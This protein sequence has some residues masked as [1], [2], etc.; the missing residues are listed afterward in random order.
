MK[1][2]Q[3]QLLVASPHLEDPNFAR[4]VI[5]LIQHGEDGTF[6]LVL[7]RPIDKTIQEL[8]QEV[9]EAPCVSRQHINLGGPVSGPLMALHTE[10]PLG[11]IEILPGVY[12]SAQKEHLE[13]LVQRPNVQLKLFIGHSGW[14]E[15]QLESEMDQGAWLV[16]PATAA[17]I[18]L[19]EEEL[20]PQ[21]SR[22]IGA[23]VLATS[24]KIKHVPDDPSVN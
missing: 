19:A 14:S 15:G 6:G 16:A 10:Q 17:Y 3:G 7:N 1:L 12:F 24:L 11:E 18:F 5:L 23:A 21:V 22:Q 8:W 2:L 20:W 13:D 4:S 9:E